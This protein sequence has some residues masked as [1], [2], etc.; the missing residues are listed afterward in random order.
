MPFFV[1]FLAP[2]LQIIQKQLE[3]LQQYSEILLALF[4]TV[5]GIIV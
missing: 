2:D 1:N 5:N 3:N 4:M